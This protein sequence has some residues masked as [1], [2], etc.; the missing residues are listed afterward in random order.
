[1]SHQKYLQIPASGDQ[2]DN[3]ELTEVSNNQTF[4]DEE[5][6][7][8]DFDG[9][10]GSYDSD[11]DD[12]GD[13]DDEFDD[14]S[15]GESKTNTRPISG[16]HARLPMELIEEHL[17]WNVYNRWEEPNS[18]SLAVTTFVFIPMIL[19]WMY[20]AF[21]F[22]GKWWAI[23]IL[24]L[25]LQMRLSIS[26]WYIRATSTVSFDRRRSLR[27]WCSVVTIFEVAMC[28]IVYPII[29]RSLT[30][31]FFSDVDG[32]TVIEWTSEIQFMLV[33]IMMGWLVVM[34]RCCIG[35]PCVAIRCVRYAYPDVYREWRPTFWTPFGE[36]GTLSDGTRYKLHSVF[37]FFNII[38]FGVNLICVLSFIS[39]FGPWPPGLS[40]PEDCDSLDSTE[41]A[42]PFPSFHHMK[43]DTSSP[44]GWRVD[45]KGMPPLRGG[46]PF[47]PKF[48]DEL[49]GFS[50][51]K[52]IK[53]MRLGKD[54]DVCHPYTIYNSYLLLK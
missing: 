44:T 12:D 13:F 21:E 39:H 5:D 30:D 28:G 8:D 41:C 2:N 47:R 37:R 45:L 18:L 22:V 9:E 1:M 19:L 52:S 36:E 51:S 29:C 25:H 32:T 20:G 31:A 3:I 48:L 23:W 49:D 14:E 35:L 16:G 27:L 33:G 15:D 38:V 53:C 11:G 4:R 17:L 34:L 42:L 50:T 10:V 54:N 43:L 40:L 46:I 6:I 26:L 7:H 24:V